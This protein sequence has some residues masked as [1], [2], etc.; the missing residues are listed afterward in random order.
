MCACPPPCAH[1]CLLNLGLRTAWVIG[2][3]GTWRVIGIG[4]TWRGL[5][6]D[7]SYLLSTK[8]SLR[9]KIERI[10][11]DSE[12]IQLNM[13]RIQD[14]TFK[15]A[16]RTLPCTL[17]LGS[18]GY[19][20]EYVLNPF[21]CGM[22]RFDHYLHFAFRACHSVNSR[23]AVLYRIRAVHDGNLI[24]VMLCFF[25]CCFSWHCYSCCRSRGSIST[26]LYVLTLS[27]TSSLLI[28]S[29]SWWS[30]PSLLVYCLDHH[31]FQTGGMIQLGKRTSS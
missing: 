8:L 16:G 22:L 28:Q 13:P 10:Q 5:P 26:M 21:E 15:V 11:M 7:R 6:P 12:R 29:S 14:S 9:N 31:L 1:A 2:I 30:T 24:P 23:V 19:S 3:G 18:G 25:G 20:I 27:E 17:N 4:R